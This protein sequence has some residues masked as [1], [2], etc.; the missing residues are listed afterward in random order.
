VLVDH[1]APPVPRPPV[2]GKFLWGSHVDLDE[3]WSK[4]DSPKKWNNPEHTSFSA[5]CPGSNGKPH[6]LVVSQSR[7]F[8][9]GDPRCSQ[10]QIA[11]FFANGTARTKP[12]ISPPKQEISQRPQSVDR[13][14][15]SQS[16]DILRRLPPQNL[17]AEQ[18]VLGAILLDNESIE[19]ANRIL[20]IEHFYRESH[21][22]IFKA[23]RTLWRDK[24]AIDA[25]TL[26][27]ELTNRK[28]IEEVGGP[29]YLAELA[30][31]VPTA[32]NIA[33]YSNIV[34]S[35]SISREI[36]SQATHI[37]TLA[38]EGVSSDALVGEALRLLN[39]VVEDNGKPKLPQLIERDIEVLSSREFA[40][41][42]VSAE[43]RDWVVD[44]FLARKEVSLWAGKVEAGKTTLMR[45]LVMCVSRGQD[46][47]ERRTYESRVLYVMLDA[48]GEGLTYEEFQ[49]LGWDPTRDEIDFLIDPVMALR[50][51]SFE[52]FHQT[53]LTLKPKFVVIDPLG[54]FQ[55]ITDF[56]GYETT[57][58]MAQFSELAKQADCHIALLHH[59]PRGRNDTDD[60]AT[61]GF[62]SI[63]IAGG[64][65]ARFVCTKKAGGIYTLQT[66]RGKGGGFVPFD[67]EQV[68]NRDETTHWVTL[69]GTYDWKEQSRAVQPAVLAA[70]NESDD[71]LSA[72]ELG[73]LVGVKR[74]IA[75]SAA[76]ALATLGDVSMRIAKGN[77]HFFSRKD[78][79]QNLRIE[80]NRNE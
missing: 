45:T 70:I 22:E 13:A 55:K 72:N 54:R 31:V 64:C 76:K 59:I 15:Q 29:A 27:A 2:L 50:P 71:E 35:K 39:P 30:S 51:N 79:Q 32:R 42:H 60:A 74:S 44:G 8:C 46:F 65:N 3:K 17:E 28:K 4:V 43:K 6:E 37:A 68:L 16:D 5:T 23:M 49:C 19:E 67:A 7:I 53:L 26:T 78:V 57:Y 48:D 33:H 66:S 20:K 10:E 69:R 61:A 1:G 21:R 12:A 11:K 40:A 73:R 9:K 80:G 75:G 38:Y 14:Q 56:L 18:S 63:A 62:G 25:V 77:K 41:R 36:A 34:K 24:V 47:L 58:A 52:Q